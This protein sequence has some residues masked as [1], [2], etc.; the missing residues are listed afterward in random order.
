MY[1][2]HHRGYTGF[3]KVLLVVC[4]TQ[5]F[6]AMLGPRR[7]YSLVKRIVMDGVVRRWRMS[8]EAWVSKPS[9]ARYVVTMSLGAW[10]GAMI[11]VAIPLAV[12]GIPV[13]PLDFISICVSLVA[14]A[15]IGLLSGWIGHDL[16][17]GLLFIA[18]AVIAP[19]SLWVPLVSFLVGAMGVAFH[20]SS[21]RGM[22]HVITFIVF[23]SI[24]AVVG[25]TLIIIFRRKDDLDHEKCRN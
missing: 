16:F 15:T 3:Q 8:A 23:Y 18:L 19:A 13:T 1:Q 2:A 7:P 5:T 11:G 14:F 22:D 10:A 9:L 21:N 25:S 20:F 6:K 12:G 17:V 4:V 24:S